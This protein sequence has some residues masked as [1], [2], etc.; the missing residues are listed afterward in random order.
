MKLEAKM[1]QTFFA[2]NEELVLEN[3]D[4]RGA[5][6]LATS[7]TDSFFHQVTSR[8]SSRCSVL[9]KLIVKL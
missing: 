3:N 5:V 4:Y 9:K 1:Q 7:F 6:I 2:T 8:S